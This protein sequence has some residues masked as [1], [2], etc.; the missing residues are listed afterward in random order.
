MHDAVRQVPDGEEVRPQ[1]LCCSV[2]KA[3]GGVSACPQAL[4]GCL[5]TLFSPNSLYKLSKLAQVSYAL[6][7]VYLTSFLSVYRR[8]T[9]RTT[10]RPPPCCTV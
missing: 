7:S 10:P 5:G 2:V 8:G 4:P 3:D 1:H 6:S 9:Y